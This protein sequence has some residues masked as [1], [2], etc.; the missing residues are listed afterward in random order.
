MS[1]KNTLAI[2]LGL[3]MLC[4]LPSAVSAQ[5]L[6]GRVIGVSDGDTITVLSGKV[7]C[8]IRLSGIDCPEKSQAFGQRA[9]EFTAAQAFGREVR[10]IYNS[11]DRY[12][13]ILGE[14]FLADGQNLNDLLLSNG[15]AWW[16]QRFS[17]DEHRRQLEENARKLKLGLWADAQPSAPW[18][19]RKVH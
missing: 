11:R 18:D 5:E 9:R 12:R 7:T 10:V 16:Y 19:Y 17:N 8:K 4:V 1:L 15:Y 13:R 14:V 2:F 3:I 6:S